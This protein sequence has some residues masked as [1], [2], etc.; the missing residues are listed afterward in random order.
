M[1]APFECLLLLLPLLTVA[2]GAQ[3]PLMS[4]SNQQ[5][6]SDV[7]ARNEDIAIFTGFTRDVA[8]ISQRFDSNTQNVTVLAPQNEAIKQ[9]PRKPWEDPRDYSTFG[10]S[11]YE[12]QSGVDRA[13]ENL[14]KFVEAHIVGDSPWKEGEKAETLAGSTVWY[15]KKDGVKYVSFGH[16]SD[17]IMSRLQKL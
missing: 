3:S 10:A 4:A 14:K 2:S 11:A 13:Q 16:C 15:E 17:K 9:L 5:T 8:S 6:I 1:H 7:I 12:G